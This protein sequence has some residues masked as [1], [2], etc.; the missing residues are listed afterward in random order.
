MDRPQVV[1]ELVRDLFG[2]RLPEAARQARQDAR[3]LQGWDVPAHLRALLLSEGGDGTDDRATTTVD[4]QSRGA[5]VGGER[6]RHRLRALLDAAAAAL[7][8]SQGDFPADLRDYDLFALECLVLLYARPAV[9]IQDNQLGPI[10]PF[11]A[12]LENDLPA[13]VT[14]QRGVGRIEL[15]GH[16]EFDWAGTGFLVNENCLMTT[17]RTAEAFVENRGGTWQFR[18]EITAW[19][20][21][22]SDQQRVASAGY[23]VRAVIGVHEQYDL[24]LLEVEA[25]RPGPG[26]PTPLVIA[27]EP[28][29]GLQGRPAYLVGYQIRDDRRG[30][31]ATVA[32]LFQ[33][34]Y[35]TKSIHPGVLRE[36][37]PFR[38]LRLLRHD[39][40]VLGGMAGACL[41]D[42][43]THHVLGLHLSGRYLERGTAIPLWALRDDALLQRAGV[44]FA[45]ATS[46]QWQS[47]VSQLERLAA[48]RFWAQAQGTITALYERAFN[49]GEPAA[50]APV[51]PSATGKSAT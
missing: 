14:V 37:I 6:L 2:E 15:L 17:R 16:P 50:P 48:T 41:V 33:N 51:E 45:A 39:C 24:A 22:R 34:D 20:D 18:P 40:T 32:R 31:P 42:L 10:A 23:H 8:K 3:D 29:N 30:V 5:H 9:V 1:I 44:T 21:Y 11:W 4:S 26:G 28:P 7:D 35:H 25:P 19:M 43:E 36:E 47:T 27:E 49:P 12:A 46:H 38:D 13:M